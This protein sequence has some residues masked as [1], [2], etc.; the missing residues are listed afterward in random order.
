MSLSLSDM[1]R[2]G[3]RAKQPLQFLG[4]LELHLDHPAL[5]IRIT[6][7]ERRILLQRLVGLEHRPGNGRIQLGNRLDCLDCTE[8]GLLRIRRAGFWQFHEDDV[9]QLALGV[10]GD[11]HVDDLGIVALPHPFMVSSEAELF[12][13]AGHGS[14][15]YNRS[16]R[17][18]S[19]AP[20]SSLNAIR[21]YPHGRRSRRTAT[22][23][24]SGE[25]W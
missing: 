11:P 2:V 22:G 5:A 9:P 18:A 14:G 1:L 7:D 21:S 25:I 15:A 16:G 12:R 20:S 17:G 10:V 13:Y 4:V 6:I 8:H 19:P 3:I 24:G 23:S